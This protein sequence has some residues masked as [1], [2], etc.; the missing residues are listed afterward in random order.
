MF[1]HRS[2]LLGTD[3]CLIIKRHQP[4]VHVICQIYKFCFFSMFCRPKSSF[5][6]QC[7]GLCVLQLDSLSVEHTFIKHVCLLY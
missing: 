4:L 2:Q 1:M 7:I 3:I 6:I 5:D